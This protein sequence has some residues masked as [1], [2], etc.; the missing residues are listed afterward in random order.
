LKVSLASLGLRVQL[1]H[2]PGER[3]TGPEAATSDFIILHINGIYQV[4]IDF[5]GC[6]QGFD[7]GTHEIQ[8][9]RA[10]WF[11]AMHQRPKTCASLAVLDKF[12][13]ETLQSKMTMYDFYKVLEK[14]MDKLV[15]NCLTGTTNGCRCAVN[16]AISYSSSAVA[17]LRLI[18]AQV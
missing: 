11:P 6:E 16:S 5:C 18:L 2:A 8:L 3:C 14:L 4:A 1:G 9:L 10:G 13:Q 12:H 7:N 15:S 17:T